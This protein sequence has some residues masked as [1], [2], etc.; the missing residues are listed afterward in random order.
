MLRETLSLAGLKAPGSIHLDAW[1]I[2]HIRAENEAD[3]FF[4]QGLNVA[5]DRLWQIDLWRK[6]GLGLLAADFG[7]GY[8]EQDRA[9]RLFLYR[10][11]MAAEWAS[12]SPDA[13]AIC[14]AFVAGI[15]AWIAR[16]DASGTALPAEFQRLGTKPQPWQPED[17]LRI[18]SHSM[19]RNGLSE[20]IR[21]N[22]M[23]REDQTVDL[24]RQFLQ[25][26]HEVQIPEGLDLAALPIGVLDLFKLAIAPVTFEPERLAATL[27]EAP[28]WRIT[29]AS[30]DV[31]RDANAQGSNNWVI[32]PGRSATGRP[33]L[34]S[35]PHR[36][37]AVPS[38][39]YIAHLTC[40]TLDVIGAGEPCLPGICI[41]HNGTAAFGL[42]LFFGPDQEDVQIYQ[43][44]PDDPLAY[45]YGE[46]WEAMTLVT[47]TFAVKGHNDQTRDLAFT[48]HGP[49]IWTDPARGLAA[50]V[51]TV[52]SAP[53]AAPYAKSMAAMRS[54]NFTE[55]RG[56]MESW[57]VPA[58]N[59]VYADT[60]GDIGWTTAGFSP[61]RPNWDGLLPVP[62]DGRFE[63]QGHFPGER[64]PMVVNP[65]KGWFATAN[66]MNLPEGWDQSTD[67]IGFEWMEPSRAERINEV[68]RDCQ[69]HSLADSAA[70]Q[71]DVLSIPARRL[72][73]LLAGLGTPLPAACAVFTGWDCRLETDSAA[74]ALFEVWWSRHL[75]P[76]L[77]ARATSDPGLRSL[78]LPG[79]PA[80]VLACL[81]APD[82]RLGPNPEAARDAL[83]AESLARACEDCT[84]LMGP[85]P[86]A[87]RWGS[88]HRSRFANVT[89]RVDGGP[90]I[91]PIPEA[92]VPGSDSTPMNALY[93]A[94][95]FT[96]TLGAS[97][98]LVLDVG[99]WDNSLFINAPGQSGSPDSPHYAD[100]VGKW[101]R[102]EYLPLLYSAAAVDSQTRTVLTVLPL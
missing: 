92:E 55:F 48:R 50:A 2:P 15:N 34:A 95:D 73:A 67:Q 75:R 61:Q 7:P 32:G 102:G 29:S 54:Q 16:L 96:V 80:G 66:E 56:H 72:M 24:L 40:P 45:R 39:R 31:V 43:L 21:A 23:A 4:L 52:W 76:M 47:E 49:V 30:G 94:A 59:L 20:V 63:W 90:D 12:Y 86:Q 60:S 83:L 100:L 91:A 28:R 70:L 6:R 11:D 27:D 69:D 88:L 38:L 77:I 81:E 36:V 1:G 71:C 44:N 97:V 10:G 33:I 46:G 25:P 8:L 82:A 74:A 9:A 62:G 35:D 14:T 13:K 68:L 22:V 99:A 79:D 65:P 57:G 37:H 19:M 78:L 18:R 84:A 87:W 58:A 42:T 98:R 89:A 64:L 53:G 51:R 93:S 26:A 5:R 17:V 41:G 3:L 101:A 85:E